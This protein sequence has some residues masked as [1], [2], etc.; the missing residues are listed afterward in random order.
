THDLL[1]FDCYP[2]IEWSDA[3]VLDSLQRT[4]DKFINVYPHKNQVIP[5]IYA[6]EYRKGF[7][8]LQYGFWNAKMESGEFNNP[9]RGKIGLCYYK[10]E[11]IRKNE[12]MQQEIKQVNIEIVK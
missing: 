3:K 6:C 8:W 4:W 7:I 12:E 5:Q 10:D 1:L 9:Y 2:R 11:F